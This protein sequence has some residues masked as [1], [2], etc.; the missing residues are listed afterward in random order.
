MSWDAF[1]GLAE[2]PLYA[3]FWF[4]NAVYGSPLLFG[5][6]T[7]D[8][9][10]A[11]RALEQSQSVFSSFTLSRVGEGLCACRN[12]SR[13]FP[14]VSV[15]FR[16]CSTYFFGRIFSTTSSSCFWWLILPT[17]VGGCYSL[18]LGILR[19]VREKTIDFQLPYIVV[20]L[21]WYL[22]G[23]SSFYGSWLFCRQYHRGGD[24]RELL[25]PLLAATDDPHDSFCCA[26]S[27]LYCATDCPELCDQRFFPWLLQQ[28]SFMD[29]KRR[30][31]GSRESLETA[32]RVLSDSI[33]VS[34]EKALVIEL[35]TPS[36]AIIFSQRCR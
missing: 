35:L 17:G 8:T 36:N 16:I 34:E 29:L 3:F 11:V 31:G 22:P 30:C 10:S 15:T 20:T 6:Q 33:V 23:S 21:R 7:I 18:R 19:V 24:D 13:D 28:L 26:N 2:L 32:A 9:S 5:Y 12:D 1:S 14:A 4:I 27:D 25:C